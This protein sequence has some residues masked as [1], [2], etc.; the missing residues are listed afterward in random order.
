MRGRLSVR[1]DVEFSGPLDALCRLLEQFDF[2][3]GLLM[4]DQRLSQSL[5]GVVKN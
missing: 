2:C 1:L 3:T 4:R 5:F